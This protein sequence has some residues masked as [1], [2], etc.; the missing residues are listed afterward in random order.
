MEH[1]QRR[2]AV[3]AGEKIIAT[4]TGIDPSDPVC[5]TIWLKVYKTFIEP[6]DGIDNGVTQWCALTFASR[7]CFKWQQVVTQTAV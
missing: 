3:N 5:H 4:L 7:A 2:E 6:I 1:L